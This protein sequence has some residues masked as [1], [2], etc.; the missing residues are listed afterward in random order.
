MK[1]DIGE[2]QYKLAILRCDNRTRAFI[3]SVSS[4]SRWGALVLISYFFYKGVSSF[5]GLDTNANIVLNFL[6]DIKVN[7]WIAY[8][9]GFGG[10]FY[11]VGQRKSRHKIIKKTSGHIEKLEKSLNSIRQSSLLNHDGTTNEADL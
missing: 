10:L 7:Q 1:N 4:L 2:R 9:L 5:S 3:V 8:I 6:S 11:G